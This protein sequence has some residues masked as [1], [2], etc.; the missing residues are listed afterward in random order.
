MSLLFSWFI[1]GCLM[2]N[3]LLMISATVGCGASLG[4]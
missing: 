3:S 2:R 4:D 1:I